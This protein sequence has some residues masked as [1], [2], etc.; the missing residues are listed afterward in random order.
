VPCLCSA[1]TRIAEAVDWLTN[2]MPS[3]K[4]PKPASSAAA[5]VIS[6][7]IP[8]DSALVPITD[9]A[10]SPTPM[11]SIT[12][13]TICRIRRPRRTPLVLSAIAAAIGAKN[14]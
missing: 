9:E 12:P 5:I 4:K 13:A 2:I 6:T 3:L 14:G 10:A 8:T 11:P 1:T 7:T